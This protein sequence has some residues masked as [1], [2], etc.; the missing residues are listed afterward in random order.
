M[1]VLSF[2]EQYLLDSVHT[3]HEFFSVAVVGEVHFDKKV[4]PD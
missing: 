3:L 4:A 1:P 2:G